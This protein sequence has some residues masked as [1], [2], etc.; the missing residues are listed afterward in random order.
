MKNISLT[1][2]FAHSLVTEVTNM[3][4]TISSN[5]KLGL[6]VRIFLY[7]YPFEEFSGFWWYNIYP[8]PPKLEDN[9]INK[10][11]FY[12][13]KK[14][15]NDEEVGIRIRKFTTTY[16]KKPGKTLLW[17]ELNC[18]SFKQTKILWN[19]KRRNRKNKTIF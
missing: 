5:E 7:K 11:I 9:F 8:N 3:T 12:A 13:L 1:T 19:E 15:L 10:V 14:K 18:P 4:K 17:S 2:H 16:L 6:G